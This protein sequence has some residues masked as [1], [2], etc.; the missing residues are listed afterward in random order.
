[1]QLFFPHNGGQA[2]C[3]FMARAVR[4]KL[5]TRMC[6]LVSISFIWSLWSQHQTGDS[7]KLVV[8]V[9]TGEDKDLF[10]KYNK[11]NLFHMSLVSNQ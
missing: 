7:L 4:W 11:N 1:M 9:G 8:K 3:G 10:E 2:L 6:S 5:T